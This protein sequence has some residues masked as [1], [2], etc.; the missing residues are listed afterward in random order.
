MFFNFV[1]ILR[2]FVQ[3]MSKISAWFSCSFRDLFLISVER[4]CLTT[5]VCGNYVSPSCI[6]LLQSRIIHKVAARYRRY[7]SLLDIPYASFPW[8][9]HIPAQAVQADSPYLSVLQKSD[10][11]SRLLLLLQ[12]LPDE[13]VQEFQVPRNKHNQ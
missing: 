5:V 4:D 1:R 2:R 11:Q 8:M 12:V 13:N 7:R 3:K 6:R 9:A 10:R